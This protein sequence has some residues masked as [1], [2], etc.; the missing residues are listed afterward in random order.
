MKLEPHLEK[1][2]TCDS[3]NAVRAQ[4]KVERI[5]IAL[6]CGD[7]NSFRGVLVLKRIDAGI[8]VDLA[9]VLASGSDETMMKMVTCPLRQ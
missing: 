9:I 4:N 5:F 2:F 7:D 8:G 6:L 3:I 1:S